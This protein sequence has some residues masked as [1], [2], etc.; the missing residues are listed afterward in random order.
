MKKVIV[1]VINERA[2][3][4]VSRRPWPGWSG[5]RRGCSCQSMRS[6][7]RRRA[8]VHSVFWSIGE[9][10]ALGCRRPLTMP[11]PRSYRSRIS[12]GG[13][14]GHSVHGQRQ[15]DT[16]RKQQAAA[17][18][19]SLASG[20]PAPTGERQRAV[21]RNTAA[22]VSQQE[23]RIRY[24]KSAVVRQT[25]RL[26]QRGCASLL[27]VSSTGPRDQL[28][29]AVRCAAASGATWISGGADAADCEPPPTHVERMAS[30]GTAEGPA[31]GRNRPPL[32]SRQHRARSDRG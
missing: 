17:A 29:S 16:S 28:S 30:L 3:E 11:P 22:Q 18:R 31:V 9:E 7:D 8:E 15:A 21:S 14:R 13:H 10:R 1:A 27:R 4:Q 5:G 6:A 12:P 2:R 20:Y 25:E 32:P 24:R 26:A 23:S 19:L